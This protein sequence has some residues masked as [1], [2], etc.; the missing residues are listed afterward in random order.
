[1][2]RLQDSVHVDASPE[3]VWSWLAGLTGHYAEWHP[4]HVSAGWVRGEPNQVGSVLEAVEHVGGRREK[5]RFEMTDIV[6]PNLMEYRV[7]GLHGLLLPGGAFLIASDGD[8][9]MFTASIQY[10]FGWVVEQ[11]FGR[12]AEALRAHMREEGVNLKRLVEAEN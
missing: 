9:S 4:D 7:V 12:R 8:G 2:R 1:M 6:A 10:R 3:Q 5:L 11:L